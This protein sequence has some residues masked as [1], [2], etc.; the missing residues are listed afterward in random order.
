M[1]R[2][3]NRNIDLVNMCLCFSISLDGDLIVFAKR[4]DTYCIQ[5]TRTTSST[6]KKMCIKSNYLASY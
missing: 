5:L 3:Q 4:L 6:A 1:M 2:L